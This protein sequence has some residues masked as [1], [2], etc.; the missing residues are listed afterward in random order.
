MWSPAFVKV[1][2]AVGDRCGAGRRE[3]CARAAFE[4]GDGR[5]QRLRGRRAAPA[6]GVAL[7]ALL[8]ALDRPEQHGRAA[9]DGRIDKA[10]MGER[11]ATCMHDVRG[12]ATRAFG[13]VASIGAG[14][15][16]NVLSLRA[17]SVPIR[18][19]RSSLDA[20]R[21]TSNSM[22]ASRWTGAGLN[23]PC[24]HDASIIDGR[25]GNDQGARRAAVPCWR[26]QRFLVGARSRTLRRSRHPGGGPRPRARRVRRRRR[27]GGLFQPPRRASGRASASTSAGRSQPPSGQQGRRQVPPLTPADSRSRPCVRGRSTFWPGTL[28]RPPDED[29]AHGV[30]TGRRPS[31]RRS[32][33][34]WCA[35]R[36]TSRARSSCRG[37]A[38]A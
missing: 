28:T 4:A 38:C 32:R 15:S 9:I 31:P 7:V 2:S 33:A 35:G 24:G 10:V 8:E 6:V 37:R 3:P 14:H 22:R 20:S 30:A 12:W 26:W 23:R 13:V 25:A 18:R 29:A 36:R 27:P 34:S 17:A 1:R 19:R 11:I 5:L 16:R 21:H